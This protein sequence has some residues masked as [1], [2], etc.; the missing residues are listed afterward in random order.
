[1]Q[2]QIPVSD[3]GPLGPVMAEA[4][5]KCVHC[6]FCL[7]ACPTYQVLGEE[8]D[9]PRGRVFLMKE[10]LEGRVALDE[11]LPYVDRC[12][13]CVGCVPACPSGVG[14]GELLTAFR[15]HAE[16]LRA[17]NVAERWFRWLI[18]A[19]LPYP[20]RFRWAIRMGR[21][22]KALSGWLPRRMAVLW[23]LL[24]ERLP[25]AA[26]LPAIVPAEPPRRARVA[27]LVGCAQRVLAPEIHESAIRVLTRNG[28][29]VLIPPQGCCGALAAHAGVLPLAR[30]LAVRNIKS[31]P[32]DVDAVITTAAGCGSG[33]HEYGLWLRGHEYEQAA[34]DLAR[35]TCDISVFLDRLG[36][37]Q[38]PPPLPRPVRVA[39]HDACHLAH[40]QNVR[41]E[42][43]RL[44]RAIPNVTLLDVPDGE[45]CCG[46]A[47]TYNMEQPEIAQHLGR[48]KA[49]AIRR[50]GAECVV[51]GNIGCM[52]QLARFLAEPPAI[53]V[54]HT[55]TLIDAAYQEKL[56]W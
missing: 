22:G 45:F 4:V 41:Q 3:L 48:Q 44:L 14:Y 33:M 55:I 50:T 30:R 19:T 53:P 32:L 16:P 1:M 25:R 2:H 42:P 47:G 9:S 38:P 27:L 6:G 18:L 7:P 28:A 37:R 52:V 40:A 31:F 24:P 21:W 23:E 10:V 5:Q 43:R 36:W 17:R 26:R 39:Y 51:T 46:S 13:G 12:L 49:A 29:D 54:L 34:V 20:W 15:A 56:L 35:K 8:M 11:A